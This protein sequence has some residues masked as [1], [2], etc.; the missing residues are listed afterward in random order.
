MGVLGSGNQAEWGAGRV[1]GADDVKEFG[2][3]G[4]AEDPGRLPWQWPQVQGQPE[5]CLE[6]DPLKPGTPKASY[7]EEQV[8]F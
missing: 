4:R 8:R 6:G 2:Y 1:P 5:E 7:R 3:S